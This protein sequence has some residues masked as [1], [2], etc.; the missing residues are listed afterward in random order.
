MCKREKLKKRR[1][2]REDKGKKDEGGEIKN[3]LGERGKEGRREGKGK[4][5][6]LCRR[7][8]LERR[9]KTRDNEGGRERLAKRELE[10]K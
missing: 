3:R 4:E 6:N 7:E 1:R 10:R 5:G 9:R 8:K 2:K